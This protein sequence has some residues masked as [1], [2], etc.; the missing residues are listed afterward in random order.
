MGALEEWIGEQ[1]VQVSEDM[2]KLDKVYFDNKKNLES[3][4]SF[5]PSEVSAMIDPIQARINEKQSAYDSYGA[6]IR[7]SK[8]IYG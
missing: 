6:L 5:K 2:V 7:R 8:D 4:N 3:T 1:Q